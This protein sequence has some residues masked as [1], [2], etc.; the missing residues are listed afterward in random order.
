[1]GSWSDKSHQLNA[2][3]EQNLTVSGFRAGDLVE[4]RIA[5]VNRVGQSEWVEMAFRM[6]VAQE[7]PQDAAAIVPIGMGPLVYGYWT[8]ADG[9]SRRS[10]DRYRY[11]DTWLLND[12]MG[13]QH[14]IL[15]WTTID[16]EVRRYEAY[17]ITQHGAHNVRHRFSPRTDGTGLT[18]LFGT[19]N[20]HGYSLTQVW[21]R[22][23]VDLAGTDTWTRWLGPIDLQ[24]FTD[25]DPLPGTPAGSPRNY[26]I[27]GRP[28]IT[29]IPRVENY[30]DL[31]LDT[32]AI[33]DANGFTDDHRFAVE[34]VFRSDDTVRRIEDNPD[35]DPLYVIELSPEHMNQSATAYVTYTDADGFE[36]FVVSN[37][38]F[39]REPAPLWGKFSEDLT[40]DFHDGSTQ[41]TT[42]VSFISQ[43][44][45]H[46][47]D[48]TDGRM[49]SGVFNITGGTIDS[50]RE[51]KI[52][53]NAMIN[54]QLTITPSG[55]D[56]V[57][58]TLPVTA[59][60]RVDNA[61][62]TTNNWRLGRD[63]QWASER[64]GKTDSDNHGRWRGVR[65][66]EAGDTVTIPGPED[67]PEGPPL[68]AGFN[69]LGNATH[70]GDTAFTVR[71]TFSENIASSYTAV[72]DHLLTITNGEVT[73]VSRDRPDNPQVRNRVWNIVIRPS[74]DS[75]LTI[76]MNP[77]TGSCHAQG[78]ICT[79]NGRK[80]QSDARRIIRH[81]S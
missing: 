42:V 19:V 14:F 49:V 63:P 56:D 58:I 53:G 54:W 67:V 9:S 43:L 77:T 51:V 78:A 33:F 41:F 22:A 59:D 6:Q 44:N 13:D 25:D 66:L 48:V 40:P 81:A 76:Q 3:Q 69:S 74:G 11:D 34:W 62:C 20:V 37:P 17:T 15:G 18:D 10:E 73:G 70:D 1:M 32:S 5:S 60:C 29:G 36:E 2:G 24:C 61:I 75:D 39:I 38:V 8:D 57:T 68:T 21:I 55:D 35:E 64:W 46:V 4:A 72:R 12:C 50:A 71:V 27:E 23:L 45:K 47:A 79:A 65:P 52:D 28:V 30:N 7:P 26:P 31:T 16:S 80:L